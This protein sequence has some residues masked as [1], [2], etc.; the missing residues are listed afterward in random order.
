MPDVYINGSGWHS[1][2]AQVWLP[3]GVTIQFRAADAAYQ[4]STGWIPK[5]VDC[6]DLVYPPPPQ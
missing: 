2:G 4:N 3:M 1:N 5:V 6:S